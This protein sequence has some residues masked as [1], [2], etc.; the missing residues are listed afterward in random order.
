MKAAALVTGAAQGVGL[1]TATLL[2]ERG[3]TVVLTDLQPLEATVARLRAA[4]HAVEGLSG[5]VSSEVFVPS[6]EVLAHDARGR[7]RPAPD[8]HLGC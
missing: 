2:A 4:G 1:A 8:I 3:Y 7:P 5:D 6:A